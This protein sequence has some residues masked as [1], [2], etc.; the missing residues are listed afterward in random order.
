MKIGE[1]FDYFDVMIPDLERFSE[2]IENLVY[3]K[4]ESLLDV[5]PLLKEMN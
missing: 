5:I 3:A 4:L 2:E 1:I